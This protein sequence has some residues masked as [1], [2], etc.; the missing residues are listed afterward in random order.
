MKKD[1]IKIFEA[2]NLILGTAQIIDNYGIT[3]NTRKDLQKQ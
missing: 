1:I 3:N 2:K